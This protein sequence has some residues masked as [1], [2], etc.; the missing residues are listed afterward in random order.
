MIGCRSVLSGAALAW[1]CLCAAA[2]GACPAPADAPLATLTAL[3]EREATSGIVANAVDCLRRAL[4]TSPRDTAQAA[5]LRARYGALLGEA[6]SP[7]AGLVEALAAQQQLGQLAGAGD[8][9]AARVAESLGVLQFQAGEL[10]AALATLQRAEALFRRAPGKTLAVA[11]TLNEL[12]IVQRE[13]GA[14]P[15]AAQQLD[16]AGEL[17]GSAPADEDREHVAAQVHNTR[18]GLLYYQGDLRGAVAEFELSR[19]AFER[20]HAGGGHELSKVY[21]NLGFMY[22]ELGALPQAEQ[23]LQRAVALKTELLGGRHTSVAGPLTNLAMVAEQ[24]GRLELA[25]QRYLAA[26]SIYVDALGSEH[27][28]VGIPENGL[29]AL[30]HRMGEQD[31]A[32]AHLEHTLGL[33]THAYGPDSTWVAETLQYLVPVYAATGH[34]VQAG[35]AAVNSIALMALGGESEGLWKGYAAYARVLAGRGALGAAAFF[36]KRA[37]NEIQAQR[38]G[39]LALAQP[40]QRSYL[41]QRAPVYRETADWLVQLGR[42]PEAHQ[43]LNMLKEEEYVDYLRTRA[44]PADAGETRIAYAAG[45]LAVATD[46]DAW[47]REAG[48]AGHGITRDTLERRLRTLAGRLG[49]DRRVAAGTAAAALQLAPLPPATAELR[50]LVLADRIDILARAGDGQWR[51]RVIVREADLNRQ[52]FALRRALEQADSLLPPEAGSLYDLLVRPVAADLARRH[53]GRLVLVPDGTLRYLPFAALHDGRRFLVEDHALSVST[54]AARRA[55]ATATGTA[56]RVAGFGVTRGAAGLAPLPGVGAELELI[57]KRDALDRDGV[58]PGEVALDAAFTATRL[59]QALAGGFPT[60]HIATH[61]VVRP[62]ALEQS[63]LLLGDGQ[64]LSLE[65]FRGA[66]FAMP[67]VRLLTLSACGTAVGDADATGR[68]FESFA[69]LAQRQGA[70]AVLASLWPVTDLGSAHFMGRFYRLR[71][72]L[73]DLAATLQRAQV[74]TLRQGGPYRHPHYWAPFLLVTAPPSR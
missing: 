49:R 48:S 13:L 26:I 63:W 2:S 14:Y 1:L 73:G 55:P 24:Q 47:L 57:V 45:E 62:G 23:W 67:S 27:P 11:R 37:V 25:R 44:A 54:P 50:Y 60:V 36:G 59:R 32:R 34:T 38:A 69:V 10:P 30:E 68:E 15:Q 43:V 17:L 61:F 65:H 16:V 66:D 8:A 70:N 31:A 42:L 29:G 58:V 18:G 46:L 4:E 71:T 51:R 12:A 6:G 40:L 52:V 20:L 28:S 9:P 74:E 41:Q 53:I 7:K 33:R 72:Q 64:P 56:E 35:D 19:L 39:L 22:F 5:E 21:N 3:A